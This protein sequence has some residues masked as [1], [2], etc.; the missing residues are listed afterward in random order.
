MNSNTCRYVEHKHENYLIHIEIRN[1]TTNRA[2]IKLSFLLFFCRFSK[3][4]KLV[5]NN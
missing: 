2:R 3:Q 1:E 5:N 4:N